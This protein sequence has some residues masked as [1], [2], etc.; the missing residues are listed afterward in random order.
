MEETIHNLK[1]KMLKDYKISVWECLY[2]SNIS[3]F[4]DKEVEKIKKEYKINFTDNYEEFIKQFEN[5]KFED[6]KSILAILDIEAENEWIN[7]NRCEASA[8]ILSEYL[9]KID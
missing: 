6:L 7:A 9:R 5:F 8:L 4:K 3:S 2:Y 1:E